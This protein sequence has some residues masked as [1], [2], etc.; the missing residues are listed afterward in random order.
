LHI[1]APSNMEKYQYPL[2]L[3]TNAEQVIQDF[4]KLTCCNKEIKALLI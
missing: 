1:K 3:Y 4:Q 2:S